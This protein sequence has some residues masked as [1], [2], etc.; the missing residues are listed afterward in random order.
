M[1]L[2]GEVKSRWEADVPAQA[3]SRFAALLVWFR[4]ALILSEGSHDLDLYGL[5]CILRWII[6]DLHLSLSYSNLTIALFSIL[7]VNPTPID[8]SIIRYTTFLIHASYG[9][10]NMAMT[11]IVQF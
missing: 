1:T 5:R 2:G 8:P 4:G 3:L 6:I 9:Q 10:L 7:I 11:T